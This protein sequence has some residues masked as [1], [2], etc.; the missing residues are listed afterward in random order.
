MTES[1]VHQ[2]VFF[3]VCPLWIALHE[4]GLISLEELALFYEDA[5][6]RRQFGTGESDGGKAF[7]QQLI[8]A[9]HM[10]SDV[11]QANERT[12]KAK[13]GNPPSA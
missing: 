7:S 1:E 9:I 13:L 12:A 8:G 10:L 4:K 11:V 6:M 2:I 5:E 3:T